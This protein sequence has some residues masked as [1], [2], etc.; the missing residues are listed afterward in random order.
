MSKSRLLTLLVASVVS[1]V[2][3][4]GSALAQTAARSPARPPR[5]GAG[6]AILD[7]SYVYKNH[8]RFKDMMNRMK[9]E[10]EQAETQVKTEQAAM[11]QLLVKLKQWK[12]GSRDYNDIQE[13]IIKRRSD[14]QVRVQLQKERFLEE[15][16]KIYHTIYQ[17]VLEEVKYFAEANG[18]SIVLRFNG[19]EA[20]V[21]KPETVLRGI[22]KPVIWY[23]ENIDITPII[24]QALNRRAGGSRRVGTKPPRQGVA[25]RRQ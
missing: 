12:K 20:D 4:A 7:I 13:Q 22:N 18:L 25:P 8:V 6:V 10:V 9:A 1:T 2:L 16:A 3:V 14:L 11:Q 17:E 23:A 19:D 15:E 5:G 21:N 24:S